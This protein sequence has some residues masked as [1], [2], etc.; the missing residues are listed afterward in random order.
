MVDMERLGGK[1][2]FDPEISAG[3]MIVLCGPRQVGKTTF[4]SNWLAPMG[5]ARVGLQQMA[6]FEHLP[7]NHCEPLA[8]R[9]LLSIFQRLAPDF[10]LREAR[11]FD[12]AG[13][14]IGCGRFPALKDVTR[15][16]QGRHWNN[17]RSVVKPT[18]R[19]SQWLP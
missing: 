4:A 11:F 1:Y 14:F 9:A 19:R 2:I 16:Q 12:G 5:V 15:V 18:I 13:R 6:A 17:P 10:I 8:P 3:K 7:L